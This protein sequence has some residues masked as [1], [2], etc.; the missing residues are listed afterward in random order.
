MSDPLRVLMVSPQF[1]PLLGGYERAAEQL[2]L[3][4]AERGHEVVVVAERWNPAWP[5]EE[6]IGPV[7]VRRTWCVHRRRLH[8]LT[9]TASLAGFLLRH[10]HR[11]DVIHVH[12][13]G[14]SA[15]LCVAYGKLARRPVVLKLTATGAGGILVRLGGDRLSGVVSGLHRRVDACIATSA[16]GE[17]EA[18]RLGIEPAHVWRIPNG[19]DTDRYRPLPEAQ[20]LALRERLGLSG[21]TALLYVGR[22][23]Q[24]KNPLGLLEAWARL[25]PPAHG[26]LVIVGDGPQ[27]DVVASRAAALGASVRMTGALDDPL[28]WYQ[29]ADV[30]VLPSLY[31]GFS[32]S[33]LEALASGLPVVSSPVSGSEDV[34]GVADVGTLVE[35]AE[36]GALAAGLGPLLADSEKREHCAVEARRIALA[37]FSL[38]HVAA[39]VEALYHAVL[40]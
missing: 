30:Y 11:F 27:R 28:P 23:S 15:A 2:S 6:R 33:L 34:F 21:V 5:R 22:L 37:R 14:W 19:V 29:S 1:R 3:A 24:E 35:S 13:S 25:G 31:E 8:K 39:E 12:Q 32:N 36:P 16:R 4:L 38:P 20:R 40:A 26:V 17:Q 10:G 18:L 9:G 7:R